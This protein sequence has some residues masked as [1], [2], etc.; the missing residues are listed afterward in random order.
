[1][2]GNR[3]I[4]QFMGLLPISRACF[5]SNKNQ[6]YYDNSNDLSYHNSWDSLMPVVEKIESLGF[7]FQFI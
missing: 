3:I 6:E 1:M 5:C 4:A 7:E 2:E